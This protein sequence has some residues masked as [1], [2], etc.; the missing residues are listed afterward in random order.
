MSNKIYTTQRNKFGNMIVCGDEIARNSYTI[1]FTGSYPECMA[2][3][4]ANVKVAN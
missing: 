2:V 3:K 1:I 4:F